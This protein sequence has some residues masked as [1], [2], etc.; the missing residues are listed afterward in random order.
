MPS[1]PII[2]YGNDLITPQVQPGW[3][4]D[5]DGFGLLQS[6]VMFKMARINLGIFTTIFYRGASHPDA[7]YT[8]LKMWRAT[9]TEEKGETVMVRADYCGLDSNVSERGYSDPQIQM[10]SAAAS[11]SI[12]S[13]PNFFHHYCT[14]IGGS[15]PLA[16]PPPAGGGF[17]PDT[18]LN[19]NRALWTPKVAG[20]GSVNNCQ[21]IGFIPPQSDSLDQ[22]PNIK[23]GVRS[24][25]K[26][27]LN[28]RV[29]FY[30]NTEDDA[31]ELASYVGWIT[32]GTKFKL[33]NAYKRL[34]KP[35]ADGG[36]AGG[37][38]YEEEWK[39]LIKPNFLVTNCSVELYGTIYKVTADLMLS[40]IGG[41]DPD[42][43]PVI[44]E[45]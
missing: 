41:F 18:F 37:I 12:Q 38:N 29:L 19:P 43:Y 33:P 20:A 26:P 36:F 16:G 5:T 11:E 8:Q 32:T 44:S 30:M 39:T 42:I 10:T 24:Y 7:N 45:S 13:H 4:V 25:Y 27:Q 31:L 22:T 2:K 35:S 17:E 6:T 3:T 34:G 14:S 21:F 9:M 23:A 28:L 40:G 1:A 15:S